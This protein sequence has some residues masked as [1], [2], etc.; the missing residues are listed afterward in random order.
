MLKTVLRCRLWT[1]PLLAVA[2][3]SGSDERLVEVS[4]QSVERQAEQN[5]TIADQSRQITEATKQF[6]ESNAETRKEVIELQ[7]DLVEAEAEARNE[8]VQI[9]Q[10]LI[11]RDATCRQ[12]LSALQRESQ[13]A[14]QVDRQSVD[15]QRE[16]LETER[17]QIAGERHRAPIIAAAIAQAGLVLACLLP[18]VL[19]GYLL[20]VLRHAGDDDAAVTELLIQEMVADQPRFLPVPGLLPAIAKKPP[21]PSIEHGPGAKGEGEKQAESPASVA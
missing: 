20:Y 7:R 17:R 13:S 8:L 16:D 1:I 10:D 19:C 11:D 3:C 2:G 21:I 4:Q 18:L 14:I 9:Q 6:V 5:Q 12:D 15:R